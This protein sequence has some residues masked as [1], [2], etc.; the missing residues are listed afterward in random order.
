M[1][2]DQ[3]DTS[4]WKVQI[5]RR[6][7]QCAS[8]SLCLALCVCS[9]YEAK[10]DDLVALQAQQAIREINIE[11]K[12]RLNAPEYAAVKARVALDLDNNIIPASMLN[13][14]SRPTAYERA[15]IASWTQVRAYCI[16]RLNRAVQDSGVGVPTS[17]SYE[18]AQ[19]SKI[20]IEVAT[21]LASGMMTYGEQNH[22]IAQI[23]QMEA[24]ANARASRLV[25]EQRASEALAALIIAAATPQTIITSSS[26][27][28]TL[29]TSGHHHHRHVHHGRSGGR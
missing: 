21:N 2:T 19:T 7:S 6:I 18:F 1:T 8:L 4:S 13:D 20:N 9:G 12:A 16:E 5:Q 25:S 23:A 3:S 14:T 26:T 22:R 27:F 10:A 29:G 17:L 11:C 28:V 15:L 24:A